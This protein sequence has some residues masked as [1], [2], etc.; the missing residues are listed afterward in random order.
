MVSQNFKAANLEEHP[1][2]IDLRF[3]KLAFSSVTC[4]STSM[5]SSYWADTVAYQNRNVRRLSS[6]LAQKFAQGNARDCLFRNT[7]TS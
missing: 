7:N 4:G 2:K 3:L 1:R 6:I 5:C